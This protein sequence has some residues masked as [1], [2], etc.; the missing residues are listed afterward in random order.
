MF[1][2][3]DPAQLSD[4]NRHIARFTL[5]FT[6]PPADRQTAL[7][8]AGD[9]NL[10]AGRPPYAGVRIE[11]RDELLW[12]VRERE[13]DVRHD[14]YAVKYILGPRG[15]H[16]E[17]AHL[18]YA[19]LAGV[20]LSGVLLRRADL[21]HANLTRATL[22]A[23]DVIDADLSHAD[24]GFST[25]E[26]AHLGWT[27]LTG[28]HMRGANL[29]GTLL[30]FAD[31]SGASLFR[32]DL[33]GASL[34]GARMSER[35]LLGR[36]ALDRT[37]RLADVLWNDAPLT[38]IDWNQL[39]R[40]G[41]EETPRQPSRA[42][43]DDSSEDAHAGRADAEA[44]ERAYTRLALALQQQGIDEAAARFAYRGRVLER[45]LAWQRGQ[46]ARWLFLALL[47]LLAGYG[48]RMGRILA[49]YLLVILLSAGAYYLLGLQ[50]P[51]HLLPHEALLV[52]VT[53]FHGRVFAEQFHVQSL[54]AWVTAF[55]AVAGL[56]I[57]GVFIAM[58]A[59][60]FF[61]K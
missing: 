34:Y 21:S 49:A 38:G 18:A 15:Q 36:I 51:P 50:S 25:I 53:A 35:T 54:Q 39:P 10:A 13:W 41:D 60:R 11:S 8:A 12:I 48:Y 45:R 2:D 19:N 24:L 46:R 31:L 4:E 47:G 30:L 55:E 7:R 28:A 32:A 17:R 59:Q 33:R 56:V 14:S 22:S 27:T 6:D 44:A 29:R 1:H 5:D 26:K 23:A 42:G 43:D 57:E 52:S 9:A 58:L 16:V 37:T 3:D 61:G 40:L 20:D